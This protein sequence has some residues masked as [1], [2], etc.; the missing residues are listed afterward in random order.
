MRDRSISL[1]H[2]EPRRLLAASVDGSGALTVTGS[3]SNDIISVAIVDRRLVVTI[4]GAGQRFTLSSVHQISI[5]GQSGNDSIDFR[6]ISIPTFARGGGGNDAIFAGAGADR[7][8]GDGGS[9]E[10]Y[11]GVGSDQLDGGTG[12]DFLS[13]GEGADNVTYNSRTAS[14]VITMQ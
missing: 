9:D 14:L 13:G 1:D 11:G 2:L 12:S 3:N 7:L 5:L 8:L 6:T 4:N 10:L